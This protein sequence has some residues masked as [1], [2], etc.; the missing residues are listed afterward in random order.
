[1]LKK[2][3]GF[4]WIGLCLLSLQL[5]AETDPNCLT[6]EEAAEQAIPAGNGFCTRIFGKELHV[7]VIDRRHIRAWFAGMNLNIPA[8]SSRLVEPFGALYFWDRPDERK[9][10]YGDVAL[11]YNTLFYAE[12]FRGNFEWITTFENFTV[13]FQ[14]N[15]IVDGRK[16]RDEEIMWGYVRPGFGLGWRRQVAPYHNDNMAAVNLTVEPGYLYFA[17]SAAGNGFRDPSSTFETRVHLRLRWDALTRNILSLPQEGFTLGGE[18]FYGHRFRWR[19]W[20]LPQDR[21]KQGHRESEDDYAWFSAYFLGVSGVPFVSSSRH[22]LLGNVHLGIGPHMDRFSH[23][24]S[25]RPM[26]GFNPLGQEYHSTGF[27]ILPGSTL[28]EFYPDRYAIVEGEYRYQLTF[29]SALSVYGGIGYLNTQRDLAGRIDRQN[30]EMPFVGGRLV[31]GFFGETVLTLDYAHN[32][33]LRRKE[34]GYGNQVVLSI[35]GQ[36]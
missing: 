16:Q 33:G 8:P 14:Q 15:E 32:F 3:N 1:M 36:F 35:S 6:M 23:T 7:P 17:D 24:P 25:T 21:E 12:K 19:D 31:T 10:F 29:F 28:L 34:T 22:R 18:A 13:P 4:G 26:G 30:T 9:L 5:H 2:L 27:P 11:F 20:G